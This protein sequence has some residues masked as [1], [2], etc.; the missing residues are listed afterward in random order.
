MLNQQKA[1]VAIEFMSIVGIVFFVFIVLSIIFFERNVVA[2]Q[3]KETILT[4]DFAK[5]IQQEILLAAA[6]NDGYMRTFSIPSSIQQY[7]YS[8]ISEG[9]SFTIK[10]TTV[11]ISMKIPHITGNLT[12]GNNSI[13]KTG[14]LILIGH[15]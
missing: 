10:T 12:K 4:E 11:D 1:Q 2:N 7:N 15:A 8:I 6:V 9:D 14:G 13:N 3:Q 5:S